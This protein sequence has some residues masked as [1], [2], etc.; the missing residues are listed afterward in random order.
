MVYGPLSD[1]FDFVSDFF[2]FACEIFVFAFCLSLDIEPVCL[3][4]FEAEEGTFSGAEGVGLF[5]SGKDEGWEMSTD[6]GAVVFDG[7]S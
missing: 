2:C 6:V 5:A 7:F 3:D 1:S 4:S